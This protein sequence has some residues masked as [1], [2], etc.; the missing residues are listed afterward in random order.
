[1]P[2][3][4]RTD[5]GRAEVCYKAASQKNIFSDITLPF[6][7][8]IQCKI[9]LTKRSKCAII[10]NMSNSSNN[11]NNVKNVSNLPTATTDIA[12]YLRQCGVKM[13]PA[14]IA[15]LEH[16]LKSLP[17]GKE[18]LA[19]IDRILE[20]S[21]YVPD[22]SRVSFQQGV[23]AGLQI[24]AEAATK[25][26]TTMAQMAGVD[27][28]VSV[29]KDVMLREEVVETEE[30]VVPDEPVPPPAIDYGKLAT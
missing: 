8:G 3:L 29:E 14:A 24:G 20:M 17:P 23:G 28:D 30:E 16:D 5:D 27:M 22:S 26:I 18:K 11:V 10:S 7:S 6:Y 9:T 4:P 12:T 19:V 25:M 13:A 21:G 1:V 2:H 15:E